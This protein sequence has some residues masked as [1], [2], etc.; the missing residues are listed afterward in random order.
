MSNI[1][2]FNVSKDDLVLATPSV[3]ELA[4]FVED[5]GVRGFLD[6]GCS[7][8]VVGVKWHDEY[9]KRLPGEVATLAL[10]E[11]SKRVDQFGG[12]ET[13][14]SRGCT[15]LPTMIGRRKSTYNC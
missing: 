12:G 10:V 1:P 6:S 3:N 4:D 14:I 15:S 2:I 11:S 5:V 8:S 13:R 9:N 7:K